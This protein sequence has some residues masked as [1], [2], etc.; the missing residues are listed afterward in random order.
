MQVRRIKF[1]KTVSHMNP[2]H[3]FCPC[4]GATEA[5]IQVFRHLNKI[6]CKY[7]AEH[8]TTVCLNH[9]HLARRGGPAVRETQ[10]IARALPY[11]A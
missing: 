7:V 9:D 6:L 3:A 1:A 2:S 8:A 10:S 4:E 11:V 5:G